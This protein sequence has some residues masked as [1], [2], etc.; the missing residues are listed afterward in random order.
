MHGV[1]IAAP[2]WPWALLLLVLL[3]LRQPELLS[4]ALPLVGQLLLVVLE[5]LLGLLDQLLLGVQLHPLLFLL[6]DKI[7]GASLAFLTGE[8]HWE[9]LE[10][11]IEALDPQLLFLDAFGWPDVHVALGEDGVVGVEVAIEKIGSVSSVKTVI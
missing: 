4:Q 5:V 10:E 7:D 3:L 9:A 11:V 8:C 1:G 2:A 6:T